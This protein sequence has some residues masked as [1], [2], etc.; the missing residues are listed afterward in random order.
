MFPFPL[1]FVQ[2]SFIKFQMHMSSD[3]NVDGREINPV[4]KSIQ[5]L[6]F[7]K[8]LLIDI[9]ISL[10][11]VITDL[12]LGLSLIFDEHWKVSS[13]YQ[14]GLLI[15]LTC[16]LPGP[17]TLI[18]FGCSHRMSSWPSQWLGIA[19]LILNSLL[20][21]L[22]FPLLPTLLYLGVLL[23]T[24]KGTDLTTNCELE[25]RAK[26]FNSVTVMLESP[27]QVVVLCFLMLKGV[28]KLPWNKQVSTACIED[29]LGRK[30]C[31]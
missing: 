27:L 1:Y 16:W 5:K 7:L 15:L 28:I 11:D 26:L 12:L 10:F 8:I 4:L 20:L 21:H 6:N 29:A 2:L 17:V 30:V 18:H 3:E 23:N 13:T 25:K 19:R 24:Q 9:G 14:Y 31:I 22:F